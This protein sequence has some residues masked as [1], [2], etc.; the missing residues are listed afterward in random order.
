MDDSDER[1]WSVLNNLQCNIAQLKPRHRLD[2]D[3]AE[4]FSKGERRTDEL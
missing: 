4:T 3:I 2:S 1:Y